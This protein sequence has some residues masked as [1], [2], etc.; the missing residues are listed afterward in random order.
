MNTESDFFS[1]TYQEA[2][3]RLLQHALSVGV[4]HRF[5]PHTLR[6]FEGE[7]LGTDV[8]LFGP[9]TATRM[10]VLESGTHG[11]EG[12]AGSAIQ[13]AAVPLAAAAA[14]DDLAVLYIHAVN[15]YGFSFARRG[16]E[17]N[18]DIN[19]NFADFSDPNAL[20]NPLFPVLAPWLV[21]ETWSDD[22]LRAAD[23]ALDELRATHG[24]TAISQAMRRGQHTHPGSVFFGGK[25]PS[26]SRKT[27]EKITAEWLAGTRSTLLL[28]VHT[29]LG[30]FGE[31][32]LLTIEPPDSET[33]PR[34][35]QVFGSCLRST[36]DARS[37]AANAT[38]NIFA[39]Y[40]R[41]LQSTDFLGIALEFGTYEQARVQRALRRDAW[42]HLDQ[43]NVSGI[44]IRAEMRTEMLE[45]F[46]PINADWRRRVVS[47]GIETLQKA[48][49]LLRSSG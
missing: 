48:L 17:S 30:E 42:V 44:D 21:P 1:P 9:K 32:Q 35:Q 2:R 28:D 25:G 16:D 23:L 20:S 14:T 49:D 31:L 27:V 12:Y 33:Y 13:L 6:G 18:V 43:S 7:E 45:T 46:C 26:W 39:G 36:I 37:G 29:G 40:R 11:V 4:H 19:R 41:C 34:L 38:G 10:L 5:Y 8:L 24:A 15:P 3:T 47:D 22:S